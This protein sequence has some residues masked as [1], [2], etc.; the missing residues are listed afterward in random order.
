MIRKQLYIDGELN[1]RLKRLSTSSGE[2]EALHVRAALR[3]YL[4]ARLPASPDDPLDRLVGLV[5]D[6]AGPDDVAAEHDHY[7]Y[8]G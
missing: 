6:P 1:T 2:S 8:G 4:D 3:A 5:S 7:L